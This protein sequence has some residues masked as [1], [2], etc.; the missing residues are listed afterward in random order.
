VHVHLHVW[1]PSEDCERPADIFIAAT[2]SAHWNIYLY[3]LS[4]KGIIQWFL[5]KSGATRSVEEFEKDN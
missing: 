3:I 5:P 2:R 1:M 4:F